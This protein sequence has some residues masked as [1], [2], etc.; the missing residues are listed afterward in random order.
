VGCLVKEG[1]G[2]KKEQVRKKGIDPEGEHIKV[3]GCVPGS[4]QREGVSNS[5]KYEKGR[6]GGKEPSKDNASRGDEKKKQEGGM[7]SKD[8]VAWTVSLRLLTMCTQGDGRASLKM[9]RGGSVEGEGRLRNDKAWG[10]NEESDKRS[11]G[12]GN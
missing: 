4:K 8:K 5:G 2:L 12:Q 9:Y 6:W 10:K 7:D 11:G 1:K 3:R